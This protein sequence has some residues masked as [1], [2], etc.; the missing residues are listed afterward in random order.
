[1]FETE[2][3]QIEEHIHQ[4]FL[5]KNIPVHPLAWGWIPFNG[6]WGISTSFFQTAAQEARQGAKLDVKKRAAEIACLVADELGVPAGFSQV[7]AVQG[8]LNLYFSSAEYMHRLVDQV[9]S[10]G[11]AYGNGAIKN[12]KVMVEFSQPNT[13]KA[14]HV[15]HLRNMILGDAICRILQAAGS[16]VVRA[17][18]IGDIGLHVMKWLWCYQKYHAGELPKGDKA[19][20]A[21][22]LYVE[23]DRRFDS[24][25][26][27]EAEVRALFARWDRRDPEVVAL[28]EKTR[29]WSLE[30]LDVIYQ[31]LDIRFDRVYFE[32]E[33]ED[34]GKEIVK[35][36][37]ARG[38]ARDE[39]PDGA[40]IVPL[41]EIL[42]LKE[43]YR[44]LVVLRSDGTSLYATKDLYLAIQKFQEY[45][46][47]KSIYVID[48]RQSLYLQQIY[49]TLELMGYEAAKKCYHLAYEIVNLPGNVTMSSREG[50][51]VLLEDLM[52]E[53]TQRALEIVKTKNPELSEEKQNSIAQSVAFGAIRYSMLSRDNIKIVTFDWEAALDFNGQAAPY[54]QYAAVRAN[55]IL[56]KAGGKIPPS[57]AP[58]YEISAA[59]IAL[60]DKISRLPREVQRAAAEYRPLY[61]AN[62]IYEI[63]RAFSDFYNECP[64]L[65]AEESV[66]NH[67]LRLVAA[68]RQA[69]TNGLNLLGIQA[70]DIM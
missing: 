21:G 45:P 38:I 28:W 20:W 25:P 57:V 7:E 32:S 36:L 67:R 37:I 39:R 15:G 26:G 1:M 3:K 42:G 59:E 43:K 49:K 23:A 6:Q 11:P 41:D 56:R 27:A 62:L 17:N 34:P 8:Y 61:L 5:R 55:S 70:P 64:V 24:E 40:V 51:I 53:A 19:A 14:F 63:A 50:T 66:R 52:R 16:S 44:V 58:H 68:T 9:L 31:K 33:V 46:L 22:D 10:E 2:Q 60:A 35:E 47:D 12:E 18:Y 54:I 69:L 30:G 29:K 65:Q 4:L 13:H 48:V